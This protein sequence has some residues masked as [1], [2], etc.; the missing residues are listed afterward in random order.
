MKKQ[1][2]IIFA[3]ITAILLNACSQQPPAASDKTT[4]TATGQTK[5]L[6][7]SA[8]QT[9][10]ENGGA[11]P[12]TVTPEKQA[13]N[14]KKA[15]AGEKAS[16]DA[17]R[18]VGTWKWDRADQFNK[19]TIVITKVTDKQLTFSLRAFHVTNMKTM[20][21]HHGTI[22]DGVAILDK[23]EAIF[24]DN[25]L[26]FPFELRLSIVDQRLFV[27]TSTDD[28]FGAFVVVHGSYTR[29][30]STQPGGKGGDDSPVQAKQTQS[31][32]DELSRNGL[33][34]QNEEQYFGFAAENNKLLSICV[35]SSPSYIVYRYGHQG[36]IELEY[37]KN[38]DQSWNS[39]EYKYY[40]R[41]GGASNEGADLNYLSFT[42][43]NFSYVIYDD[44]R[45][46]NDETKI[47]I[48]VSDKKTNAYTLIEG[49]EKTKVGGLAKLRGSKVKEVPFDK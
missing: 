8:T 47:G 16:N 9:K 24:R 42:I 22:E 34:Y 30:S 7:P 43:G 3:L 19:S 28:Y 37:P 35:S 21:G 23:D 11:S 48:G 27:S 14:D 12:S 1:L 17:S 41:P 13:S 33:C 6:E 32:E 44:Y 45:A 25:S 10:P 46:G 15:F 49:L 20:E 2:W 38:K 36:K 5:P 29:K 31:N 18:W 4:P 39:F 26:G 40:L